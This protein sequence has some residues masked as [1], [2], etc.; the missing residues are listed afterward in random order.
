MLKEIGL[1]VM[2]KAKARGDLTLEARVALTMSLKEKARVDLMGKERMMISAKAVEADTMGK[3]GGDSMMVR[4]VEDTAMVATS[5]TA[6]AEMAT[7]E[8]ATADM[9]M[10]A[11]AEDMM[12]RAEDT[13]MARAEDMTTVA[14]KARAQAITSASLK[15]CEV[16]R[17]F[18]TR[19]LAKE[20]RG[21][22]SEGDLSPR[23]DLAW[24]QKMKVCVKL[25]RLRKR[26]PK[27]L[28]RN[29]G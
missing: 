19:P 21:S 24:P 22:I 11:K 12:A 14:G 13:M 20:R 4:V 8:M 9:M 28:T 5:E 27:S 26:L 23:P 15:P 2:V 29:L 10:M 1:R 18:E 16:T 7:A 17:I 25:W 3:V 6:T